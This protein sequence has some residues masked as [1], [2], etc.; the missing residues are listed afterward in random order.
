MPTG[1][2]PPDPLLLAFGERVQAIRVGKGLSREDLRDRSGVSHRMIVYVEKGLTAP[3]LRT[4]VRLAV[5]LEV[6]PE[7]LVAGLGLD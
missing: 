7:A 1:G 6:S 4:I 2:R 5:A 3:S